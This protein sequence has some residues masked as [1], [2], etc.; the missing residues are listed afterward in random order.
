MNPV[1]WGPRAAWFATCSKIKQTH[2]VNGYGHL[3][4]NFMGEGISTGFRKTS[5]HYVGFAPAI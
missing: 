1:S 4:E 2:H 5:K 3:A